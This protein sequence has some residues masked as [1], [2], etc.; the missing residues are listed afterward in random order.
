MVSVLFADLVGSTALG[1]RLDSEELRLVVGE[2]V[3]RIV[4]EVERFGGYVKDLAGDGVLAFFGAP[5]A[6]EDDAERAVRAGLA[7]ARE[8]SGYAEE[9]VAAWQV[10][11]FG[12]RVGVATGSVVLGGVGAGDRVEYAAT[13][14]TV[15]LAARLQSAAEP[16]AVLVD[17]TTRRQVSRLFE[18]VGP[19]RLELKGLAD[20]VDA[21]IVAHAVASTGKVRDGV[22]TSPLVG[23]QSEA[24]ALREAID[25]LRAGSGGVL[26][27]MGEAG[28][29]KSRLLSELRTGLAGVGEPAALWLEGRCVS[30]GEAFPLWPFRDLLRNWLDVG[31]DEPELRVRVALRRAVEELFGDRSPEIY[32]YL[33]AVLELS[34]EADTAARVSALSPEALQYRTF[35]VIEELLLRL[36][37]ERPV[38]VAI[39]DLHWADPTSVQLIGQLV[40]VAERGAVLVAIALR[41]DRDHPSWQLRERIAREFPH[42]LVEL[43]L[44]P[45][46]GDARRELLV[47]MVGDVLPE[48]L[49]RRV[50]D[51]AE[52]NPFYLEELVRS[53]ADMGALLRDG[54]GWRFDHDVEVT[55]PQTVEKVILARV[56]RLEPGCHNVLTAASTLGRRFGLPLLDAVVDDDDA[57]TGALH[58]LQRLDLVRVERRW[59]QLEYR[60]KH[61]LIQDVCYRTLLSERRVSLHRSAAEYLEQEQARN[62]DDA[63]GLIARHWLAAEDEAKAVT[64]LT[65]AGDRARFV[66][67][68]DEA[69]D[70][71]RLL[72]PLLERRGDQQT[73]ALVLFKLALALHASLRFAEANEIFQEAFPLWQTPQPK[74]ETKATLRVAMPVLPSRPDPRDA[75]NVADVQLQMALNDR[76]VE[77]WPE[78]T[79]VP[80]L[81]ERWEISSDGLRYLF[82]LREGLRWSDEQPITAHDVEYGIKRILDPA[83]P[84]LPVEIYYVLEHAQ[85]YAL[86]KAP[87]ADEVGV[88]A[89]DDRTVE[90]RLEAPAPYF[91]SVVNRADCG[92]QPRHAIEQHGDSWTSPEH[93]VASGAFHQLERSPERIVLERRATPGRTGNVARVELVAA[94]DTAIVDLYLQ[95]EIDIAAPRVTQDLSGFLDSVPEELQF[96]PAAWLIYLSLDTSHP[97]LANTDFRR[98]LAHTIDRERLAMI[99]P[100]NLIVATGGAVPPM[101]EGHTPDITPRYDAGL[102]QTLLRSSGVTGAELTIACQEG[103]TLR[104]LVDIITAS[105]TNVLSI[106]AHVREVTIDEWIAAEGH[107]ELGPIVPLV[108]FPGYTD[109]EYYLRLLLHTDS[110]PNVSRFSDPPY[111]ELLERGRREPDARSRLELYHQA[112]RIAVSELAALIPLAYGRNPVIVKPHVAGWWEF[113]KSWS[114]FADLTVSD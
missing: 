60:F 12:V 57:T 69:V 96:G 45:L 112:D 114:S 21:W 10:H 34:A 55:V 70:E 92:P 83:H 2:A 22:E 41:D 106:D 89:L 100:A 29:G 46:A 19:D 63:L 14:N 43:A 54:D 36:A 111:D 52:G 65:R 39:E 84:G 85:N 6:S 3:A 18:L 99:A 31:V 26:L 44:E 25:R 50:L 59:P 9:V 68:L 16:G 37:R 79:I 47:A 102:A 8:L 88:K 23:R 56:D 74:T 62:A 72:L 13:G 95:D 61:A 98:A 108:W 40:P 71:Y 94:T 20:P 51:V 113:G 17:S 11:G 87:R 42:L 30:Y 90:F 107:A 75:F 35:E 4:V 53:L 28:I 48:R 97:A 15:N 38:V 67:A 27:L 32:P 81:A 109:P 101:L 78:A 93:H 33:A 58:E 91:L 1:G 66:H 86:G 77:R 24:A 103:T 64:Y 110:K 7:I 76:L 5:V 105:W 80:S 82:H 73:M 104:P 49:E